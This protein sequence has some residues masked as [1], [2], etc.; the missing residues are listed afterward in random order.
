MLAH[1]I[2][3]HY[4]CLPILKRENDRLALL[5]AAFNENQNFFIGTDSAPHEIKFKENGCNVQVS[6]TQLILFK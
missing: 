2:K 3:P 4:Y 1:R 5:G 6:L